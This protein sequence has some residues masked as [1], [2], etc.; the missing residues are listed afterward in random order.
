MR[1]LKRDQEAV[2]YCER[3]IKSVGRYLGASETTNNIQVYIGVKSG[4]YYINSTGKT[5]YLR[6]ANKTHMARVYFD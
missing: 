6:E 4:I 5:E 3:T 1:Q 2:P